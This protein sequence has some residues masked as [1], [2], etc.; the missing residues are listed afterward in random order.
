MGSLLLLLS[1]CPFSA[2]C[3]DYDG[4]ASSSPEN[5]AVWYPVKVHKV[6][7]IVYGNL[8]SEPPNISRHKMEYREYG[9]THDNSLN[10]FL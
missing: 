4:R 3:E 1:S 10:L 6:S 5:V 7:I 8:T 2:P 9:I